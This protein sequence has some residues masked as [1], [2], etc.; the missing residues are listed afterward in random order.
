[1]PQ[2]TP[3]EA[4]PRRAA[5]LFGGVER[6]RIDVARAIRE[7]R[8]T[9]GLQPHEVARETGLEDGALVA[10]IEDGQH[11]IDGPTAFRLM[12]RL[13]IAFDRVLPPPNL[14]PEGRE[15]W[16][17][18]MAELDSGPLASAEGKGTLDPERIL[19][20]FVRLQ[21]IEELSA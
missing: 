11:R 9:A 15:Y 16:L 5:D 20:L 10:R 17:A 8:I 3:A 18:Q 21:A 19:E 1:M 13:G 14:T 12:A 7:A 4:P 6:I 2:A